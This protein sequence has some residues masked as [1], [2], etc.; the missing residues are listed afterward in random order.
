MKTWLLFDRACLRN[1]ARI[2]ALTRRR[3]W[4]FFRVRF[5]FAL[6]T[7]IVLGATLSRMAS[8]HYAFLLG[9]AALDLSIGT[10]LL[11][12]A[13]HFLPATRTTPVSE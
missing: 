2:D 13:R 11:L 3:P 5:F 12:S 4:D 1:L 7:M 6:A 8:G 10:A 9:V